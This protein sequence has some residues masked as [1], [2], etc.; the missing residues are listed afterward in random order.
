M[1]VDYGEISANANRKSACN[2]AA[3]AFIE[4]RKHTLIR[5]A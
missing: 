4:K 3:S 1:Y 5:G 2:A